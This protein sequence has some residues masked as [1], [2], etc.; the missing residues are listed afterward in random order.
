MLV[1]R[2]SSSKLRFTN[3]GERHR[4]E[5][6]ILANIL[7]QRIG[8]TDDGAQL[9]VY[10]APMTQGWCNPADLLHSRCGYFS[11]ALE[12][13]PGTRLFRETIY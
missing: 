2:L 7:S 5:G 1:R 4:A 9:R 6:F 8:L 11:F 13:P 10:F 12:K 3:P